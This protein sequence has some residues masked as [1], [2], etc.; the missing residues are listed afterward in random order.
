[1]SRLAAAKI[2]S[3]YGDKVARPYVLLDKEGQVSR[4]ARVDAPH[5]ND[6]LL[7]AQ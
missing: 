5:A 1:M 4:E 6:A 2:T 3:F 7:G